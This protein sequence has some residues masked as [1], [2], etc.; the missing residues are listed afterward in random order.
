MS[1]FNRTRYLR[2]L[3]IIL[4][5]G[6][7][8][9]FYGVKAQ[10]NLPK[11]NDLFKI[12]GV[13]LKTETKL[14]YSKN[15]DVYT[16]RRKL[17]LVN[18]SKSY[19]FNKKKEYELFNKNFEKGEGEVDLFERWAEKEN[20]YYTYKTIPEML[21]LTAIQSLEQSKGEY[22]LLPREKEDILWEPRDYYQRYLNNKLNHPLQDGKQIIGFHKV[23]TEE[24]EEVIQEFI[25]SLQKEDQEEV[26]QILGSS[27]T[28]VFETINKLIQEK[29]CQE[30]Q[31]KKQK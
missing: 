8:A 4:P 2:T 23:R 3:F 27:G 6:L 15:Y 26:E 11:K 12:S 7:L 9:I 29:L 18:H 14:E 19:V 1:I 30:K 10:F 22:I 25:G 16:E 20:E 28:E 31:E 24:A 21:E 17:F 5:F 13:V